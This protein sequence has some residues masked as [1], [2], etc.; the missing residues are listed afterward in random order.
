MYS[1][2][3]KQ[4]CLDLINEKK[5]PLDITMKMCKVPRKSLRRWSH[6]GCLRKKGCGRKT[7]NPQMEEKLL[8]WYNDIMKK[9]VNIT[10][11]M[12]RDKAVEISDDKDF[13]ASKGWLEKFKKKF[14][15]R[16]NNHKNK[17]FKKI[18]S[19]KEKVGKI[20]DNISYDEKDKESI[21]YQDD[22]DSKNNYNIGMG[23]IEQKKIN[24]KESDNNDNDDENEED[25][26]EN[27]DDN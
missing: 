1:S 3:A 12:I 19:F 9:N 7:K 27:L 10:A 26:N 18:I 5:Y 22:D 16:I 25:K 15:I 21:K 4:L 8:I 13:L 14:G 2:N 11:K 23:D 6:V 20:N 17:N 24:E